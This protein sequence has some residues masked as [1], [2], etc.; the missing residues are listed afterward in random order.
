M[1]D[2]TPHLDRRDDG[3]VPSYIRLSRALNGYS[4]RN[5]YSSKKLVNSRD[6]NV[7]LC[8]SEEFL[9]RPVSRST[10]PAIRTDLIRSE[11]KPSGTQSARESVYTKSP[12]RAVSEG[13]DLRDAFAEVENIPKLHSAV[14]EA[15][16]IKE[17]K[18]GHEF[19]RKLDH[20]TT[21]LRDLVVGTQAELN[22]DEKN[23][24]E[25]GRDTF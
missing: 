4:A 14:K 23:L 7:L 19:L 1:Q 5:M 9:N 13:R 21:A 15:V 10:T 3:H 12:R 17:G 24:T 18:P 6:Y 2:S 20:E 25:N 22:A 8:R 16:N 11:E